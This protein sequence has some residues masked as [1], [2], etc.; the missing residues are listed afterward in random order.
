MVQRAQNRTEVAFHAVGFSDSEIVSVSEAQDWL[1]RLLLNKDITIPGY[2][3]GSD[4]IPAD[5]LEKEPELPRLNLVT[6]TKDLYPKI[7]PSLVQDL[8]GHA[9][10]SDMTLGL[11]ILLTPRCP[12]PPGGV[13][14]PCCSRRAVSE[15]LR[16]HHR[17][18]RPGAHR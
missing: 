14:D 12:P 2:S 16:Q 17:R 4:E 9:V 13:V 18:I 3:P 7:P 6:P 11:H 5:L 15:I 1:A 8:A 10:N